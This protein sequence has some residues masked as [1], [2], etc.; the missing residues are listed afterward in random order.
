[1]N[2]Q[3]QSL[4]TQRSAPATVG[5][6][7]KVSLESTKGL[8]GG[9]RFKINKNNE[10]CSVESPDGRYLRVSSVSKSRFIYRPQPGSSEQRF[11]VDDDV[12]PKGARELYKC[13]QLEIKRREALS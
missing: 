1:M 6:R 5:P 2:S 4:L 12:Y 10:V 13:L 11:H 8:G 3:A 9:M 7:G